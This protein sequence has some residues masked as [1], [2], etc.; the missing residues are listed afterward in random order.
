[1]VI[2]SRQERFLNQTIKDVLTKSTGS[3]EVFPVLDG[4]EPSELIEDKRVTYIRLPHQNFMQKRQGINLAISQSH[5]K[6]VMALDAHCMM[7][8]GFDKV[9]TEN[10]EDNWVVIPRRLRLDPDNWCLQ[11]CFKLPIDY[12]Y[13]MWQGI[14]T[15]ALHGF[16]WEQRSLER[17][18]IPIDDNLTFQGSCWVMTKEWF[19]KN[20]FMQVEGY[21]GWGQE[22]EELSLT[23]WLNGGRVVTNK[24]T[25]VAHLHKGKKYGRMYRMSSYDRNIAYAYTFNHWVIEKRNFFVGLINKFPR[26]PNWPENWEQI[27]YEGV[28]DERYA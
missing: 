8:P 6:Y 1:V 22:A 4:Y 10:M 9:L 14:R 19:N 16:R 21:S 7:A 3:I 24:N 5:G 28:K 2:P 23:T 26:M 25:W 27:I 11:E 17:K 15:K 12:E 18:N 20:K 13:W